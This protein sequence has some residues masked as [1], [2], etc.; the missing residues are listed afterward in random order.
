MQE[1]FFNQRSISRN[2]YGA[3]LLTL[4]KARSLQCIVTFVIFIYK[5]V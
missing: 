5:M 1:I 3:N 4:F 2:I